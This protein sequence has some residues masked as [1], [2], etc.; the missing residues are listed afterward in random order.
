MPSRSF[1][2]METIFAARARLYR[3]DILIAGATGVLIG[4]EKNGD[5][6]REDLCD[7]S[8]RIITHRKI[9]RTSRC[10]SMGRFP[11]SFV[12]TCGA[13][14]R[15]DVANDTYFRDRK[16]WHRWLRFPRWS[17]SLSSNRPIDRSAGQRLAKAILLV[18]VNRRCRNLK[19]CNIT[20]TL[21]RC[22]IYHCHRNAFN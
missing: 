19:T 3:A 18:E 12:V 2:C 9:R 13:W 14:T 17:S 1:A 11:Q 16:S 8:R 20:A 22:A 4:L 7:Y 15:Q 10:R 5:T 21:Y 6:R